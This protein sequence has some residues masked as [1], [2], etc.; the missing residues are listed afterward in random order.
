MVLSSCGDDSEGTVAPQSYPAVP[1]TEFGGARPVT[2]QV[3]TTYKSDHAAPLLI[4]L[5]GFGANGSFQEQYLKLAALVE[6]EGVLILAPDGTP[7]AGDGALFWNA[8]PA[9]CDFGDTKVDDV[10]YIRGLIAA[11]R[12]D[13]NVDR[14][15]I[16][17]VGHSNG[18]FMA[19]RLACDAATE[20]AAIVSLAG[21]TF[22]DPAACVPAEPVS[23]LD[24]HGDNDT[25]IRYNGGRAGA[26]YPSE[27]QT[28]AH[29]QVYDHC[30]P[31]LLLDP[32]TLNLDFT[33]AGSETTIRRFAGC[34]RNTDVE[35]WTI[36]GGGH[37]PSLTHDFPTRVWQWLMDHPKS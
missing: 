7:E 31:G 15:R 32:T 35:L 21:A 23:V 3:P 33:L 9:C 36:Q 30:G 26:P 16:Y 17:V 24:I 4:I 1:R 11:V 18:G 14:R 25:T 20:I 10:S 19:H 8:T 28:M 6:E 2:L 13:Y 34:A 5:H 29:W 27:L 12:Q 22:E 37:I